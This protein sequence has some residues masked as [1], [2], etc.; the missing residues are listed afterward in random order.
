MT[1]IARHLASAASPMDSLAM[2]MRALKLPTV[3][4][5]AEEIAQKAER[6]G[7]TFGKYLHHLAELELI[8]RRRRRTERYLRASEL[9]REK[10]LATLVR[11]RLPPKVAKTL[12]MLCEGAFVER[13]DNLLAFGLPGRGKT[14]R[15]ALRAARSVETRPHPVVTSDQGEDLAAPRIDRHQRSLR[16]EGEAELR[17]AAPPSGGGLARV[18]H[19]HPQDDPHLRELAG[20]ELL[21]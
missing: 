11:G 21:H 10:T 17:A 5:H 3:A 13:G 18:E 14:H 8:E 9:P 12:P 20:D 6:E 7:W 2:M 4:L 19:R 16:R 1:D 15:L